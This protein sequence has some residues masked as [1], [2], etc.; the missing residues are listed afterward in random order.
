M[1]RTTTPAPVNRP[2]VIRDL[3]RAATAYGNTFG[4]TTAIV[5]DGLV[6]LLTGDKVGV[7]M[8]AAQAHDVAAELRRRDSRGPTLALPGREPHWVFLADLNGAIPL[9]DKAPAGVTF[10]CSPRVLALPPTSLMDGPVRWAVPPDPCR[11]WLPTF[12]AVLCAIRE[13]PTPVITPMRT[14]TVPPKNARRPLPCE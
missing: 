4:W 3:T 9:Q 13:T 2:T 10:V 11:R 1:G 12:D 6:L 8:P 7:A 5:R 14:V